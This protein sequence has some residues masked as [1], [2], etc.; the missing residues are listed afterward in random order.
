MLGRLMIISYI[1]PMKNYPIPLSTLILCLF[2]AC[3]APEIRFA[4]KGSVQ[5]SEELSSQRISCFLEDAHGYVWMGTERGLNRFNG[6]EYKQYLYNKADTASLCASIVTTLFED[7]RGRIWVGTM[8]GICRYEGDN[9]FRRYAIHDEEATVSQILEASD[10]TILVNMVRRLYAYNPDRE[11]VEVLIDGLT[12]ANQFRNRSFL[13]AADRLW[14]ITPDQVSCYNIHTCQKV[15]DMPLSIDVEYSEM[16]PDGSIWLFGR[17]GKALVDT[18]TMALEAFPAAAE[19]LPTASDLEILDGL[20]YINTPSEIYLWDGE[21]LTSGEDYRFPYAIAP[22]I[23]QRATVLFIDSKNNLWLA[24]NRGGF[25]IQNPKPSIYNTSD[26]LFTHIGGFPVLSGYKDDHNR[27]WFLSDSDILHVYYPDEGFTDILTIKPFMSRAGQQIDQEILVDKQDRV[28]LRLDG[29]LL[30]LRY[31]PG[32][33]DVPGHLSFVREHNYLEGRVMS[34]AEAEDGSIYAGVG[35]SYLYKLE[36]ERFREIPFAKNLTNAFFGM[37]VLT[38]G[39]LA[40]GSFKANPLIY[41]PQTGAIEVIP[42]WEDPIPQDFCYSF[43]ETKGGDL[44]ICTRSSGLIRYHTGEPTVKRFLDLPFL[45]CAD[46][47]EDRHGNL[48]VSTENGLSRLN[49]EGTLIGGYHKEDG[50]GGNQ[51]IYHTAVY[52]FSGRLIF[53]GQHGLT[54]VNPDIYQPT[55]KRNLVFEELF[56]GS[57]VLAPAPGT[58]LPEALSRNPEVKLGHRNNHFSVSFI[59][60]NPGG[61]ENAHYFSKLEGL[62]KEWTDIGSNRRAYF[63]N[64]P[65]GHYVVKVRIARSDQQVV[66]AEESFPLTVLPAPWATWW[67]KLLYVLVAGIALWQAWAARR[68][69]VAEREA[70]E[71]AAFEK[72]QEQRVNDMNM[73]FFANISHEFR[74]PLTMISGPVGL[75]E[76][77]DYL[78]PQEHKLV[79][80]IKWNAARMLKLVNQLMDFNKLENDALRLKVSR[81]DLVAL[82]EQTLA[83]FRIT[84]AEKHITLQTEG[85]E[86]TLPAVIDP[87][88]VDK[89]LTNLLSNAVKYTPEDGTIGVKLDTDGEKIT[90]EVSDNGPSIPEDQLERIFERYFQVENHH[91][92]GTGIG[93]YFARRLMG[94]HH[95]SIHAENLPQGVKFVVEF[96]AKD[97]Y[98]PEEHVEIQ[99]MQQVLFPVGESAESVTQEHENTILLVDDDSGIVNYLKLLLSP[100]YNILYAY[101]AEDALKQLEEHRPDLILSDVAMPGMDGYE[102]CRRIKAD[103]EIC[104]LP[105]ILVTAKTTTD[106]QI[107]GLNTGADAYVTKPFDPEYL[108]ALIRSQLENRERI[109]GIIANAT[110]TEEIQEAQADALNQQDKALMDRLYAIM[111]EELSNEELNINKFT[112]MM[113]MSRTKLYYKIKGLTGETPNAFFKKYKL[114]RAAE[115]LRSGNHNVSEVSDLT[116][117]SSPTVFTRNFRA[118]F[119]M[120][121]TE[122]LAQAKKH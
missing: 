37:K 91:N 38:D 13:D 77:T 120:T 41:D 3:S 49:S 17:K 54:I 27:F 83:M 114:N 10:G 62:D 81:Q 122:Y 65:A 105:V 47:L 25:T 121:P 68:R 52:G 55:V 7:S 30:E 102:F 86:D 18:E 73:R 112:E 107:A 15:K 16:L 87:D 11:Q 119:G 113:Y 63:N 88:K 43:L 94:L 8:D 58:A 101:N 89:V 34:M 84:M 56:I 45:G 46:I 104:H 72:E 76:K 51:F 66:E 57:N 36:G 33:A 28:W 100:T 42:I 70:K 92:Y 118:Q 96:P 71:K 53:G 61:E 74:T 97:I 67:A 22:E 31:H 99:Q 90:F 64:V 6:Y 79:D 108:Q 2:C 106:E 109:R 12:P 4:D 93:L 5:I 39:R 20:T 24:G 1:Y 23:R 69:I 50:L 116:G 40:I 85:L 78:K 26:A 75:L 35:L 44:W 80:T 32:Q 9:R 29:R 14:S 19:S 98:K 115:M 59:D 103:A 60:L 21:K 82:T 117:F 110:T 95:G 48:W 111:E